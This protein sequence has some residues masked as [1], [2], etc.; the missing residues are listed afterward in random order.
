M[1]TNDIFEVKISDISYSNYSV[2]KI[3]NF[4]LFVN[5]VI[6]GDIVKIKITDIKKSFGYAKP[7][8][9]IKNSPYKIETSCSSFKNGCGGC[10]W[11]NAD[12]KQQLLWKKKIVSDHFKRIGKFETQIDDIYG[13]TSPNFYRNKMTLHCKNN[14]IGFYKYQSN[15][16]V[17]VGKC[18]I[19]KKCNQS[20]FNN[21]RLIDYSEINFI[22]IRSNE[23]NE[24]LLN[25]KTNDKKTKVLKIRDNYH[26]VIIN[27]NLISGLNYLI[28]KVNDLQFMIPYNSFFQVNYLTANAI[29]KYI[30]EEAKLVN[31]DILLDLYCGVGFFS[32]I[33]SKLCKKVYGIDHDKNAIIY[34]KKNANNNMINNVKF[35][36]FNAHTAISKIN[37]KKINS[38]L[39]DPPRS[40][41]AKKVLND[42]IK[43]KPKKII[44]I[45]CG[46]DTL[47][48]D[49]AFLLKSGYKIMKCKPFDMFPHT[50]HIE[51]VI[52]LNKI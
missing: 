2:C 41:C 5:N 42:I 50:Y 27:N 8:E 37:D 24:I 15:D 7:I 49:I 23:K 28:E 3:N 47:A 11:L 36:N 10:S 6:P 31:D 45:S 22:Q 12:Y 38:I 39:I 30:L 4:V 18:Y 26:G 34:A 16:I 17:E 21:I 25:I 48:R 46:P 44:Y 32:L 33:L 13:M 9:I 1:E 29:L 40:G 20:A 35:Y 51:T 14:L 52:I 43:I 19:Q